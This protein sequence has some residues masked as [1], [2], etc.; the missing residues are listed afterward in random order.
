MSES[1]NWKDIEAELDEFVLNSHNHVVNMV[2]D[3]ASVMIMIDVER[4]SH[5]NYPLNL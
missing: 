4:Q 2:T 1:M 3:G 5:E